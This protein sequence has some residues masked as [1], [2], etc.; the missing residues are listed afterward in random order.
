MIVDVH[1]HAWDYE[2]HFTPDFRAQAKRARA[3][4]EV[5]LSVSYEHYRA[6]CP[7]ETRS[8]VFGVQIWPPRKNA[9]FTP[10]VRSPGKP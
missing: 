8:I 10:S 2:R 6:T 4:V 1:C 7:P 3:G 5:D 9:T